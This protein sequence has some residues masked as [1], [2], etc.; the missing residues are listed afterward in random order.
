MIYVY[1]E[2]E[3][4]LS[5]LSRVYMYILSEIDAMPMKTIEAQPSVEREV[6]PV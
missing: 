5:P 1:S 2:S 6:N 3:H 4:T